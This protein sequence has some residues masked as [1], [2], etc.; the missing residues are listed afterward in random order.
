MAK[1]WRRERFTSLI[2]LTYYY[3]KRSQRHLWLLLKKLIGNPYSNALIVKLV[4]TS[5]YY[6]K[7]CLIILPLITLKNYMIDK[8]QSRKLHR[9]LSHAANILP[10]HGTCV[11]AY[12]PRIPWNS[13]T[14][15]YWIHHECIERLNEVLGRNVSLRC[16]FDKLCMRQSCFIQK[17]KDSCYW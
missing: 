1:R 3:K 15:L 14:F 17:I 9:P 6:I 16:C 11:N 13:N 7:N 5:W 2:T 4:H 12:Y 10:V 8:P